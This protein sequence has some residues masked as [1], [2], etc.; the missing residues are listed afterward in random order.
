MPINRFYTP[1]LPQYTSQFVEDKTP[2]DSIIGFEQ[3]KLQ[4]GEK[5]LDY[6]AQTD[7]L[8]SSLIPGYKTKDLAPE[9]TAAYKQKTDQ[10]MKDYGD[11]TYS[12]PAL[13]ALTKINAEFRADPN[14]KKI[15]Q[16]RE[17]SQ[18]YE[19]WR[20]SP[21]YR[22]ELDPNIDQTTGQIKQ[23][24]ND[25][26]FTPYGA[27][28]D[29]TNP[30]DYINK[31]LSQIPTK[32]NS[33][34]PD[35]VDI[36]GVPMLKQGIVEVRGEDQF[37]PAREQLANNLLNG[38]ISEALSLKADMAKAGTEWNKENIV[39]Y[40]KQL[41]PF[42]AVNNDRTQVGALPASY[43]ANDRPTKPPEDQSPYRWNLPTERLVERVRPAT[44]AGSGDINRISS[45]IF[46]AKAA[47]AG[48]ETNQK[49]YG[50]IKDN[51]EK[52]LSPDTQGNIGAGI[53][54]DA[55][56]TKRLTEDPAGTKTM[57]DN[58]FKTKLA[59]PNIGRMERNRIENSQKNINSTIDGF[60][61]KVKIDESP[62]T[63]EIDWKRLQWTALNSPDFKNS[64]FKDKQDL[65]TTR[66]EKLTASQKIWLRANE[67]SVTNKNAKTVGWGKVINLPDDTAKRLQESLAGQIV[68]N[69]GVLTVNGGNS[70]I[71]MGSRM[72][73]P[74]DPNKEWTDNDKSK[75]LGEKVPFYIN[76]MIDDKTSQ[77]GPGM[78]SVT[79]GDKNYYIQGPDQMVLG[80]E[81]DPAAYSYKA[82]NA[83]GQGDIFAVRNIDPSSLSVQA[84]DRWSKD[85]A[86]YSQY[87]TYMQ[88]IDDPATGFV[89]VISYSE[90]PT[91]PNVDPNVLKPQ[92]EENPKGYSP[93][94]S[95]GYKYNDTIPV[96][97]MRYMIQQ[98]YLMAQQDRGEDV[99]EALIM[100]DQAHKG[101]KQFLNS[102]NKQ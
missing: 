44:E 91:K 21:G 72:V 45:M 93:P 61:K 7:A 54:S 34:D 73:D 89:S 42:H 71:F 101:Y 47:I 69:D 80:K 94:A 40:I 38:N 85:K 60:Y 62:V 18:T 55:F 66:P 67:K 31:Y 64:G 58:Y 65:L 25:E 81:I 76:G 12:L 82:P 78:L 97:D 1:S 8:V 52:L 27:P 83:G 99:E 17:F 35:I 75:V 14:V 95:F 10:W 51:P 100:S 16:D 50:E 33:I 36:K 48:T 86:G 2:W 6:A 70:S 9:V 43:Y 46:G 87:D 41:E 23:F 63:N 20:K 37:S 88:V 90:D 39:N 68:N 4:R 92:S 74:Q 30:T 53:L 5:A 84:I 98:V 29:Y 77:Y 19:A 26:Q 11:S 15:Q 3:E 24:A 32:E 22:A 28:V 79:I 49:Y 59:D 57:F 13:R 102:K 96:E 56:I